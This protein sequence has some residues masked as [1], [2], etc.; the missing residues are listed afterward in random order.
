V[1]SDITVFFEARLEKAEKFG[2]KDIVLDVGIGFGKTLKHNLALIAHLEH[3][4]ILGHPLLI[5]ASRKSLIDTI[6][7]TSQAEER[8]GGT[9]AIHLKAV[10][11][12]AEI[13][14]V[15]DVKEHVQALKVAEAIRLSIN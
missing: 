5:G 6:S 12:G 2:I 3:F 7:G 14:R 9:L 10:E 1:L 4:L 11:N 15:H 13:V 8:L